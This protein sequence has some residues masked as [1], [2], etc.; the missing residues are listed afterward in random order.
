MAS[1]SEIQLTYPCDVVTI[2]QSW[3]IVSQVKTYRVV[4]FTDDEEYAPTVEG[5]S[6]YVSLYVGE[7]PK[8]MTLRNCF[9][10]LFNGSSFIEVGY[11]QPKSTSEDLIEQNR[12]ALI[13][14]LR[15]K[16]A[17]LQK[18]YCPSSVLGYL[19]RQRKLAEAQYLISSD[20]SEK[21]YPYLMN[22]AAKQRLTIRETANL[23]LAKKTEFET[24][25][26]RTECLRERFT[27]EIQ[28]ATSDA[29]LV[30]VSKRLQEEIKLDIKA[31]FVVEFRQLKP[32]EQLEI[33]EPVE[34]SCERRR[35]EIQLCDRIN[36]LRRNLISGYLLDDIVFQ[37]ISRLAQAVVSVNSNFEQLL[38]ELDI[39]PLL[40]YAV[41]HDQTL[42]EAAEN[43]LSE[44]DK[45]AKILLET[46]QMKNSMRSRIANIQS[47]QDIETTSNI[48]QALRLSSDG[49][50]NTGLKVGKNPNAVISPAKRDAKTL[51]LRREAVHRAAN[52]IPFITDVPRVG[53]LDPPT[54]RALAQQ[55]LPFVIEGLANNWPIMA[56]KPETLKNLFGELQV[57][58]RVGDYVQKAFSR[59][60]TIL[61]M[62]LAEYF[63]YLQ[64]DA[65]V[66][67]PHLGNQKLPKLT[68]LCQ[69]PDY[70]QQYDKP[71]V[72]LGPAGT[73]TPLYC[74]YDDNLVVQVFGEKR[75]IIY[76]PND[77]ELFA[78]REIN[79]VLYGSN[80]EPDSP[81]YENFPLARDAHSIEC[82]VKPGEMLFLPAGWFHQVKSLA[83]SLSV[84]RWAYDP[85]M[86][87]L[88]SQKKATG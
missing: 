50:G 24:M 41:N 77:Y 48:I 53:L 3:T 36:N 81:D 7:L 6:Y 34:L 2:S 11:I 16:I 26:M 37:H 31:D 32:Q 66:V 18:P 39:M 33:P 80:F 85:P 38:N 15:E 55:G 44:V 61:E 51:K 67:P 19:A 17:A 29:D 52:N 14:I 1:L 87:L 27:W 4:Y 60:R 46:E 8:G 74:D 22:A 64:K 82:I 78:P 5:N 20:D 35:L 71:R 25:L 47:F 40:D 21:D 70:Y 79:P 10:W 83:F 9:Y 73:I 30:A 56:L 76:S 13:A 86:A 54:F 68:A 75:F 57:K 63:D 72:W 49:L 12:N 42:L 88:K 69:W 65:E 23:I 84:N 58:V 28:T 62:S 59:E 43:F 45:R